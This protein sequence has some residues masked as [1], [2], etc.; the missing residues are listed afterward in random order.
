MQ[1]PTQAVPKAGS[2]FFCFPSKRILYQER[3]SNPHE[4]ALT[5]F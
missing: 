2:S 5:R 1:K 3:E 4:L